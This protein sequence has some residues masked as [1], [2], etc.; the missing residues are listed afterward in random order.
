MTLNNLSATATS[1]APALANHLWQSTAFA[2]LVTLLTLAFR[3]NHARIRHQLW[4]VASLKFLIPFSLF[5]GL[6][7]RLAQSTL[8]LRTHGGLYSAVKEAG[9]PFTFAV[10]SVGSPVTTLYLLPAV[11]LILWLCGTFTVL[12]LWLLRWRN[13]TAV[14]RSG[15]GMLEGREVNMLRRLE[16]AARVHKPIECVL[17]QDTL[18]PGIFGILRPVLLWPG[19]LSAQLTDKQ[20]EAI[21]THELTHVRRRDNLTSALHM[22]VEAIVWFHPLTWWM[23]A[24]LIEES[25]RACDEA[26]LQLGNSPQIY[27][28]SILKTCEFCVSAPLACI[29]GVTGGDL[30]QRIVR[31]MTTQPTTHLTTG[32]RLLLACAGVLALTG[33][34][35]FGLVRQPVA[36]APS[37]EAS[38]TSRLAPNQS[39]RSTVSNNLSK[40]FSSV[41]P[42]ELSN[43]APETGAGSGAGSG[44][45]AT[46]IYRVGGDVTAPKLI[47]APDPEYSKA[48]LQAKYQGV[49]V[50]ALI[51]DTQGKPKRIRVT[52]HLGMGLD[53]QAIEA[54]KQYTFEPATRFG[55][56]VAVNIQIEVNFRFF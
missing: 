47:F 18:E 8:G 5:I 48:A 2:L 56:P 10:T 54:V 4:L 3:Q 22:A 31:I 52:R 50:V 44:A 42:G 30:K 46:H 21:L 33:P 40:H 55:K 16:R 39:Q 13:V 53:H 6:G 28:E 41:S 1:I 7:G 29:S 25:E 24:R 32:K 11:L 36:D 23:G 20:L 35:L 38:Q 49:C 19:S 14:M 12:G 15:A 17:S 9:E 37:P 34:V 51:V 45:S 43:I 27:A 26:V